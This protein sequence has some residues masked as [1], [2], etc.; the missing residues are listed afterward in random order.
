MT[1]RNSWIRRII[2]V[3]LAAGMVMS[4]TLPALAERAEGYESSVEAENN[5]ADGDSATSVMQSDSQSKAIAEEIQQEV[6]ITRML[7]HQKINIK[8]CC[9][10]S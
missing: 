8:K 7:Q 10:L 3:G 2:A 6:H 1:R 4:T 9:I 5:F